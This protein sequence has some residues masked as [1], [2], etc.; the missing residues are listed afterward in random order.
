VTDWDWRFEPAPCL[1]DSG[2]VA[3]STSVVADERADERES[4]LVLFASDEVLSFVFCAI[5]RRSCVVSS[6]LL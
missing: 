2:V 1:L 4:Q 5:D 6:L 3:P